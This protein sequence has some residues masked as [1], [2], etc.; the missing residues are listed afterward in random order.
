MLLM[1][2]PPVYSSASS[3]QAISLPELEFSSYK[4]PFASASPVDDKELWDP[5]YE[6]TF[7]EGD[8]SNPRNWPMVKRLVL[9][10]CGGIL[11]I[12]S[13]VA[14]IPNRNWYKPNN[15]H[16]L[17]VGHSRVQLLRV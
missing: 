4:E 11:L 13:Y 12:N 10:L 7:T 1:K 14:A 15:S 9:T 3:S 8:L 2:P 6:V 17:L 5:A 16:R